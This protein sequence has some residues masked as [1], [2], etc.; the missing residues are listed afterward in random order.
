MH[1]SLFLAG[2]AFAMWLSLTKLSGQVTLVLPGIPYSPIQLSTVCISLVRS[3][4][5]AGKLNQHDK[6]IHLNNLNNLFT[7]GTKMFFFYL[8][9]TTIW[10]LL[11]DPSS[12]KLL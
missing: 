5:T 11:W 4:A 3:L 8:F 12:R 9:K 2:L 1:H 7:K 6:V 10:A